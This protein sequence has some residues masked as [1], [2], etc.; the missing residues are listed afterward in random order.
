MVHMIPTWPRLDLTWPD[1]SSSRR[2]TAAP[3]WKQSLQ[4]LAGDVRPE[5]KSAKLCCPL[6]K[7]VSR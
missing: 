1:L 3:R 7:M 4:V 6:R 2:L 5:A